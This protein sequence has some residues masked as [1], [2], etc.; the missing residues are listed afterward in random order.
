MVAG[1]TIGDAIKRANGLGGQDMEPT[2][3]ISIRRK[4]SD[5][6]EGLRFN[7]KTNPNDLLFELAD[8][9]TIVVQFDVDSR[10][11]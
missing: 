5:G 10:R 4:S 1:S 7:F 11:V 2:G 8:R 3:I 9:D 6:V